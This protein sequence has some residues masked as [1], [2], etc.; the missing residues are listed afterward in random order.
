MARQLISGAID[1]AAMTLILMTGA[2]LTWLVW[3]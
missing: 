2:G 3:H 1:C